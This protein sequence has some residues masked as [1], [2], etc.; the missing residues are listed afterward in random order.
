ML[1]F[2][3]IKEYFPPEIVRINPKGMLVEYLQYEFMDSLY[4]LAGSENLSFIG[5]TAIHFLHGSKRFSEDLDFD[6]FGLDY[7]RFKLLIGKACGE[8]EKKGVKLE[9]R[10]LKKGG[11][12]H[13]YIKFPEVLRQ[14]GLRTHHQEKIFISVDSERKKKIFVPAVAVI[15][16]FGVFRNI[17]ANPAPVLLSQKLITILFRKNEKGRDFYDASFLGGL[18]KPDF[19]YIEDST[20]IKPEKF[21][22]KLMRHCDDLDYKKLSDDVAPFL[23]DSTDT[24]RIMNFKDALPKIL[25]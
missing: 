10:F 25:A 12:F 1:K 4:K 2:E 15:N 21:R 18:T 8:T 20:K 7:D 11:A 13:C 17:L 19:A 24:E 6:N 3:Q 14:F 9:I 5:G 22:I 16:K 23:F